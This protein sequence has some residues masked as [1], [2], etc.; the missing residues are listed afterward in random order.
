M[1]TRPADIEADSIAV[2]VSYL[3]RGKC[4]CDPPV[5]D[6]LLKG[7][8]ELQHTRRALSGV[9]AD[10]TGSARHAGSYGSG[11]GCAKLGGRAAKCGRV[12]GRM[13]AG[14]GGA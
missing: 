3:F 2:I 13:R 5:T 12:S 11:A 1:E 10:R 7:R 14:K 6:E 4:W 9:Q 8:P